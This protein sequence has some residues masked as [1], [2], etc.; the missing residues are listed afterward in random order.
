MRFSKLIQKREKRSKQE[1][2]NLG[3]YVYFK[4]KPI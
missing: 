2:C 3:K 1:L 4:N